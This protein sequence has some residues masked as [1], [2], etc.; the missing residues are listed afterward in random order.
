VSSVLAV[1]AMIQRARG[2][3][4]ADD[5]RGSGARI[6]PRRGR[7]DEEVR[8]PA[9]SIATGIVCAGRDSSNPVSA[10]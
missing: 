9:E 3:P 10:V 2:D 6:S 4:F 7:G 8:G 5:R 1:V